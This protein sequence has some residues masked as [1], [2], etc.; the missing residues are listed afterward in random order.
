[1]FAR[2]SIYENV[3]LTLADQ[4]KQR[5]EAS[6]SDPS[7]ISPGTVASMSTPS[8]GEATKRAGPRPS[9]DEERTNHVL[10]HHAHPGDR[11]PRTAGH[12]LRR[13]G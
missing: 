9:A 7:P 13:F 4:V 8:P 1:M 3:D 5:L 11:C 6:D 10:T 12:C 2:R